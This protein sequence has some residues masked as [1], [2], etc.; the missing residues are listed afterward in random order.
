MFAFDLQTT[1][2][3]ELMNVQPGCDRKGSMRAGHSMCHC[4]PLLVIVGGEVR[5]HLE[6]EEDIAERLVRL[7]DCRNMEPAYANQVMPSFA[8]PRCGTN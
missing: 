6:L 8:K 2:W 1:T 4:G 7:F 5:R 3:T